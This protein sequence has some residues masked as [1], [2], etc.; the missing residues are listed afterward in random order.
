MDGS[1]FRGVGDAIVSLFFAAIAAIVGCAAMAS[2]IVYSWLTEP[3]WQQEAISRGYALY[4]PSDGKFAWN[5]ECEA[6]H[7]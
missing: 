3:N 2:Y 7:D 6:T 5:N 4:C 1:A